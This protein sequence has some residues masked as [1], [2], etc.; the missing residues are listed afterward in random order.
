M[1]RRLDLPIG[2]HVESEALSIIRKGKV[3]GSRPGVTR[4]GS[5]QAARSK[6]RTG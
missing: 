5:Y 1:N 2:N 3:A 4:R 6:F